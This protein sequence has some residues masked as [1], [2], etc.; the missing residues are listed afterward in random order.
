MAYIHFK[1]LTAI[2]KVH[3]A[4]EV[5]KQQ[6]LLRGETPAAGRDLI[7]LWGRSREEG[8]VED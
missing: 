7:S 2:T 8:A 4:E 5:K 6:P 1:A 3:L